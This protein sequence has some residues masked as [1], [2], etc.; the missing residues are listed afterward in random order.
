ME[1]ILVLYKESKHF[2]IVYIPYFNIFKS[3][4]YKFKSII[5]IKSLSY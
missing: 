3:I 2:N 5:R 1:N 4:S